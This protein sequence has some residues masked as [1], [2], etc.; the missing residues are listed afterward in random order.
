MKPVLSVKAVVAELSAL[1][2]EGER[3]TSKLTYRTPALPSPKLDAAPDGQTGTSTATTLGGEVI[4][5]SNP[6]CNDL[7]H[8]FTSR[9]TWGCKQA[10]T[11][12]KSAGFRGVDLMLGNTF[13]GK[14]REGGGLI[15][16]G[17]RVPPR[18]GGVSNSDGERGTSMYHYCCA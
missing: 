10:E 2:L 16:S 17:R 7:F 12:R 11:R 4:A 6:I 5:T 8:W 1:H 15:L 9:T 18:K 13:S 3:H 14:H